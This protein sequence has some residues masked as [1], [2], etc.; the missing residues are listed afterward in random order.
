MVFLLYGDRPLARCPFARRR[1]KRRYHHTVRTPLRQATQTNKPPNGAGLPAIALACAPFYA[2][3][4]CARRT[5]GL[6]NKGGNSGKSLKRK[7][8]A[9]PF[10]T[11]VFHFANCPTPRVLAY[12]AAFWHR[13]AGAQGRV[14]CKRGRGQP[15]QPAPALVQ[16]RTPLRA[17]NQAPRGVFMVFYDFLRFKPV[18]IV[19]LP[20]PAVFAHFV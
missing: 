4:L 12:R 10:A 7:S 19:L 17:C 9:G 1:A 16:N 2:L 20:T 5:H 8:P 18:G 6:K 3:R 13:R 14:C 11:A 15:V